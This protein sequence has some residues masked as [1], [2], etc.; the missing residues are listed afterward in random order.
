L[1]K[2]G[3]YARVIYGRAMP[4]NTRHPSGRIMSVALILGSSS[5]IW[6]WIEMFFHLHF[7]II[8]N[9]PP[10]NDMVKAFL[11]KEIV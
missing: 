7:R 2:E 3:E 10:L 4:A 8:P 1:S 5:Q 6:S 11:V 9:A